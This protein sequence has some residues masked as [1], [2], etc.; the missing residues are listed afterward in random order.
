MLVKE[1]VNRLESEIKGDTADLRF[2]SDAALHNVFLNC[3]YV[4]EFA[5]EPPE[6]C[7]LSRR[8]YEYGH[9]LE[10]GIEKCEHST[11]RLLCVLTYNPNAGLM[12]KSQLVE[13][14]KSVDPFLEVW[15]SSGLDFKPLEDIEL[16]YTADGFF[17]I[18]FI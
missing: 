3:V 18:S 2:D 4:D 1:L 15:I 17:F 5:V 9:C 16:V 8:D 6:F 10:C 7:P 14:L 11:K 13:K 12:K